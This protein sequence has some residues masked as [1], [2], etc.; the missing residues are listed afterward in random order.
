MSAADR[1]LQVEVLGKL[2]PEQ[3]QDI[4]VLVIRIHEKQ[5]EIEKLFLSKPTIPLTSFQNQIA[6]LLVGSGV[7]W[8]W[9]LALVT[10]NVSMGIALMTLLVTGGVWTFVRSSQKNIKLQHAY[11]EQLCSLMEGKDQLAA[12]LNELLDDHR[13]KQY[14]IKTIALPNE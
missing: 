10:E 6:L 13:P 12:Q 11:N 9:V 5:R 8:W 7:V 3:Q 1:S 14:T 4:L 2:S